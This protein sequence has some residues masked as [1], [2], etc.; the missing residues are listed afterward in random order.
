MRGHRRDLIETFYY[1]KG[2]IRQMESDFLPG[3]VRG[4]KVM[5][6]NQRRVDLD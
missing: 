3:P 4:Q 1:L 2:I 6:L 5:A